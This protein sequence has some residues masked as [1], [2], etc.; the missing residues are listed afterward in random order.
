MILQ[1]V[2]SCLIL[3]ANFYKPVNEITVPQHYKQNFKSG[4]NLT[5]S[6][7]QTRN[8]SSRIFSMALSVTRGFTWSGLKYPHQ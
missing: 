3:F 7:P 4:C 2:K 5:G 8:I 6:N 1:D